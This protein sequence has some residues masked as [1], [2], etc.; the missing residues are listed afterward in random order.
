[1]ITT[2]VIIIF[3][4]YKENN[5]IKLFYLHWFCKNVVEKPNK[6][7]L[8]AAKNTLSNKSRNFDSLKKIVIAVGKLF[9]SYVYSWQAF[10]EVVLQVISFTV[11]CLEWT[12]KKAWI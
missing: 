5:L 6:E 12:V 3:L 2:T 1:M 7:N 4:H 8:K 10:A 11:F 9:K